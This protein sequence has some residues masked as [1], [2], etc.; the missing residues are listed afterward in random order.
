MVAPPAKSHDIQELEARILDYWQKDKTF[1]R[2][3]ENRQDSDPFIF[4]EG[5]PTANGM[6]GIH[7]VLA[8][9]MKDMVCRYKTMRGFIVKR[10]GGWDTHGLPVELGVE[11]QL[12]ISSKKE[13]E[14]YGIAPFNEKCRQSVFAYEKEWRRMTERM[15]YWVDLDDPYITLK[16]DYIE[17]VWWSL[18]KAWDAG[19]LYKG[20]RITPYCPRCGTPLSSHEVALG[21]SDVTEP[22]LTVK[23]KRKDRDD[24]YILAWTTTPWTLPGNVALAVGENIEYVKVKQRTPDGKVEHY[25]L[26]KEC[27]RQR[28]ANSSGALKGEFDL[29]DSIIGMQMEGW[30]YEPLFDTIPP[31][32][33]QGHKAFFVATA[34]FVTTEADDKEDHE[35]ELA[36]E[37]GSIG[38][39]KSR[40]GKFAGTGVVH[41]A[42]MYGED[43]YNLG[44]QL[45]LPAYHTVG[46]DGKF[47]P[48]VKK[49][50]GRFVKDCDREIIEDLRQRG[51]LYDVFDYTHSYPFC[52]RCETPLLYYAR[53]SWYIAM[54]TI[55]DK[56]KDNNSEVRWFPEHIGK[57]NGRFGNFLEELKDWSL[58][59]ERYWGTPLPIWSCTKEGCDSRVC[60][61]S[62]K[63]IE[64]RGR[65]KLQDLHRPFIDEVKFTCEKCGG[66]MVREPYLIDV[67]YD[68]G[69]SFFAQWHYPFENNEAFHDSF[70]VDF[71]SEAIDQTRGWFY[72]LLACATLTQDSLCYRTC[73]ST[74]HVLDK[75]GQKMSKSKGNVVDPWSI[76]DKEGA[77]ALRWYMLSVNPPWA[78][79]KFDETG[80]VEVVKKLLGTLWNSYAFYA[81]YA[82]L[83][84]FDFPS[85]HLPALERGPLDRWLLS[86][87]HRTIKEVTAELEGFNFHKATRILEAFVLDDLSNW[88]IRRSRKRFWGEE[89]TVDKRSGYSTLREALET[90]CKLAAP[91]IPFLTEEIYQKITIGEDL[92][93]SIHL[94]DW[95]EHHVYLVDEALE[96]TMIN[97]IQLA[98][99][100]RRLRATAGEKGIKTRQ[101]LQ[102]AV[103]V[104]KGDF[105]IQGLEEVLK[106]ELNIKEVQFE[107]RLSTFQAVMVKPN[108]K[109][110]G[111]RF[112]AKALA[113][114]KALEALP[115]EKA[116]AMLEA[117]KIVLEVEGLGSVELGTNE[118][119]VE[120]SAAGP[121]QVMETERFAIVLDTTITEGLKAEGLARELN[122][123]VQQARKEMGL[124]VD[125]HISV[126]VQCPPALASTLAPWVDYLKGE[127]RA[128]SFELGVEPKGEK[129]ETWKI[130]ED[131]VKVGISAVRR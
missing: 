107:A 15:A 109:A 72:S 95:P 11:K 44:M 33:L 125:D 32:A 64:E 39:E 61:G 120:R 96:G 29:E 47:N 113:V 119:L 101:P 34:D 69:A 38:D 5:P 26:A 19:L 23:F 10:K 123:R 60:L 63:D 81:Q 98:E 16:N 121:Y 71:I 48:S 88:Y 104:P 46:P 91:M 79:K 76:F 122:R 4:L 130:D 20:Y 94:T 80:V 50:V 128:A 28:A 105:T 114:A 73:L 35:R 9:T 49:W 68:S 57:P 116:A 59:R 86:R 1:E 52:W 42:V 117:G 6:P 55:R 13:I 110:I 40:A 126:T 36:L 53:D 90:V 41:T 78:P 118:V 111:P 112:K 67:W 31:E 65:I 131:E 82:A 127:T 89:M 100:G 103:V 37:T 85:Q 74:G 18:K 45:G 24:E 102:R 7:H 83:D 58:S 12:G 92:A 108:H 17:S 2:S 21:Y 93:T 25:W 70:P 27:A 129:V 75:D 97:C 3:I 124:N 106:E 43:D 66:A 8:R 84:K 54:S 14:A 30:D 22:S 87:L 62:V 56:V 99:A 115:P 51:L 77:D